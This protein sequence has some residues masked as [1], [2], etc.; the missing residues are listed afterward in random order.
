MRDLHDA[1][2][3]RRRRLLRH[4][5]RDRD[6]AQR[7]LQIRVRL[8]DDAELADGEVE[9]GEVW[10]RDV[11]AEDAVEGGSGGGTGWGRREAEF[12]FVGFHGGERAAAGRSVTRDVI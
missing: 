12:V 3:R 6:A 8:L 5:P 4:I 1:L 10:S 11:D 9:L 7:D 2:R